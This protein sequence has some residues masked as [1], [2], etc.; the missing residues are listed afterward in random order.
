MKTLTIRVP[1]DLAERLKDAAGSRGMSVNKIL[2]EISLQALAAYD[3]ETRFRLIWPPK[4]TSPRR[5]LFSI[6][7]T[8]IER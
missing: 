8:G 6:A 5:R 7:S 3:A 4:P 1:D 2:T